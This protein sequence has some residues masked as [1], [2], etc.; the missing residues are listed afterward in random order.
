MITI[1][2]NEVVLVRHSDPDYDGYELLVTELRMGGVSGTFLNGP[3]KGVNL[4]FTYH[5]VVQ[6]DKGEPNPGDE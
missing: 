4:F 6:K 1:K 3:K 2:R 5:N